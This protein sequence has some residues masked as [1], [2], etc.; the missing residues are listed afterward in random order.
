MAWCQLFALLP[1][2]PGCAPTLRCVDAVSVHFVV[3]RQK[4]LFGFTFHL[5]GLSKQHV[6]S[7]PQ[8]G[9]E[10]SRALVKR[11]GLCG[12]QSAQAGVAKEG[13]DRTR[14]RAVKTGEKDRF[15]RPRGL[16]GAETDHPTAKHH[17]GTRQDAAGAMGLLGGGGQASNSSSWCKM[18]E[19]KPKSKIC[20]LPLHTGSYPDDRVSIVRYDRRIC[21]H[22][23]TSPK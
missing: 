1:C 13:R 9:R 14:S 18:V 23:R 2:P 20:T 6:R 3:R 7:P 17:R 21:S 11:H 16:F 12:G 8:F 10:P 19:H 22:D 4:W 15:L 5:P